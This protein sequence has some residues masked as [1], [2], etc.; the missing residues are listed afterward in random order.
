[1]STRQAPEI[2]PPGRPRAEDLPCAGDLF[3]HGSVRLVG[4]RAA[5]EDLLGAEDPFIRVSVRLVGRRVASKD[6]PGAE[7][8]RSSAD[9]FAW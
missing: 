8:I 7:K 1:M 9:P 4:R 2:R 5:S 3:V 6:L